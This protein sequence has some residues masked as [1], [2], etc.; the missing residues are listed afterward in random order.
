VGV[1]N[2]EMVG[3][4]ILIVIK[5][6]LDGCNPFMHRVHTNNKEAI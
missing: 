5:I 1:R 4:I 2:P 6:I 3:E